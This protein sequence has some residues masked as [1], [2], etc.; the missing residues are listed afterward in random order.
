MKKRTALKLQIIMKKLKNKP[1][2]RYDP[3]V[4]GELSTFSPKKPKENVLA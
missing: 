2:A 3:L 4:D 1:G